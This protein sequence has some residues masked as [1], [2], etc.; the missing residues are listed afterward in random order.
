MAVVGQI[1]AGL[2]TQETQEAELHHANGL[3][4]GVHIGELKVMEEGAGGGGEVGMKGREQEK[5]GAM[6]VGRGGEKWDGSGERR[7]RRKGG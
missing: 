1:L 4:V 2:D 5:E 7:G 3:T 6:G